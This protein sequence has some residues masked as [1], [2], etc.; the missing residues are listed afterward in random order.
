MAQKGPLLDSLH[1]LHGAPSARGKQRN[2]PADTLKSQVASA[3]QPRF[4]IGLQRMRGGPPSPTQDPP[5]TTG[6]EGGV[7]AMAASGGWGNV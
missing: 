4:V 6:E 5:E 1:A 2:K 7:Q 3:R